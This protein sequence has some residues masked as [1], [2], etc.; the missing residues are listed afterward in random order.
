MRSDLALD[1]PDRAAA[2]SVIERNIAGATRLDTGCLE[3]GDPRL[4]K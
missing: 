2:W 1:A 4:S 3:F